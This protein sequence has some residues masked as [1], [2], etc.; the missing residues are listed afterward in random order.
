MKH[1]TILLGVLMLL[2]TAV[3]AQ[4]KVSVDELHKI[5]QEK[6]K[7]VQSV[8]CDFEQEK[9]ME[10]LDAVIAS[11]GK[12]YFDKQNRLLWEYVEPFQYMITINNGK[13]TINS[14]GNISEHDIKSNK[15]F[16]QL[17][18]LI[19]KSVNGTIFTDDSFDV[20]AVEETNQYVV[21]LHTKKPEMKEVLSKI[22]LLIDKSNF[23]VNEVKMY[24]QQDDFTHIKFINKKFNA[25]IP[26]K[27]ASK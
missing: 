12:L 15:M 23:S 2:G 8:A 26:A 7:D 13:F 17:S 21:T 22:D 6:T 10:Y 16:S 24:E 4:K 1:L 9:H 27:L 11:S 20:E 3:V 18:D 25:S 14:D 5:M 19:I